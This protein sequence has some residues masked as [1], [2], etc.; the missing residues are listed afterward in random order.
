[1][2]GGFQPRPCLPGFSPGHAVA[3]PGVTAGRGDVPGLLVHQLN[4]RGA[5]KAKQE[6][7][8][9]SLSEYRADVVLLIDTHLSDKQAAQHKLDGYS[10]YHNERKGAAHGGVGIAVRSHHDITHELVW[11][12][13]HLGYEAL[14]V[15]VIVKDQ[16][17]SYTA[18][19]FPS[20]QD[21]NEESLAT[22]LP[23]GLSQGDHI[24]GGDFNSRHATWDT[25]VADR[26]EE[27]SASHMVD[28]IVG[29]GLLVTNDPAQRTRSQNMAVGKRNE[30]TIK[31]VFSSPDLTLARGVQVTAWK[32]DLTSF[33]ES[34]HGVITYRVAGETLEDNP[35]KRAFWNTQKADW[36]GFAKESDALLANLAKG[37]TP[38][39]IPAVEKALL[40]AAKKCIPKGK[41]D[42]RTPMWTPA[43]EEADALYAQAHA[44]EL[45]GPGDDPALMSHTLAAKQ[46]RDETFRSE[47]QRVFKDTLASLATHDCGR[48]WDIIR[49]TSRNSR[50]DGAVLT[51]EDG[52]KHTTRK[53]QA[54]AL[55]KQYA[56][57]A[58]RA[59]DSRAPKKVWTNGRTFNAF[60]WDE[61]KNSLEHAKSN[62]APGPDDITADFVKKVPATGQQVILKAINRTLETGDVP[63]SWRR[64]EIIP[65]LKPG[66]PA[67]KLKSY[68]P[69]TLTAHLCKLT[70]RMVLQRV[71]YSVGDKMHEAQFGFRAGRSTLDAIARLMQVVTDE[72]NTYE[73][74]RQPDGMYRI[75]LRRAASVLV[76]F[77]SAF[78]TID[79]DMAIKRLKELG[80]EAF[81]LRWIRNFLTGR[82]NWVSVDGIKSKPRQFTAG[83]PQG[84]VLGP[85]IFILAVDSLLERLSG[86]DKLHQVAYADDLT[87]TAFGRHG[88]DTRPQLQQA[89]DVISDWCKHSKMKVNIGKT[90]GIVFAKGGMDSTETYPTLTFLRPDGQREQI[91]VGKALHDEADQ[92][93]LLGI[94]LDKGLRFARHVKAA[95]TKSAEAIAQ[96]MV[97]AQAKTGLGRK[98]AINFA[99]GYATTKLSYGLEVIHQALTPHLKERLDA[100]H[101]TNVR[102]AV[103]VMDK[104]GSRGILAESG[105]MPLSHTVEQRGAIWSERTRS[106]V[107]QRTFATTIQRKLAVQR[108]SGQDMQSAHRI[109]AVTANRGLAEEALY[110]WAGVD[111]STKRVLRHVRPPLPPHA[112]VKPANLT[113]VHSLGVKKGTLTPD[114]QKGY[115]ERTLAALGTPDVQLWTDGSANFGELG[116]GPGTARS[117]AGA[118][119][120]GQHGVRLAT[121]K[122]AAGIGASS[123]TAETVAIIHGLLGFVPVPGGF[124][125]IVTD[126]QSLLAI[127]KRGPLAAT[128]ETEL[129]LWKLVRIACSLYSRVVFHHVFSH[130]GLQW[131]E[132]ADKAAAAACR[133]PQSGV[134]LEYCDARA[135]IKAHARSKWSAAQARPT[136]DRRVTLFGNDPPPKVEDT[137][138][139]ELQ[140]AATMFR[141][142][143]HPRLGSTMRLINKTMPESCRFCTPED[144]IQAPPNSDDDG[145]DDVPTAEAGVMP[146]QRKVKC[147]V[148]SQI[149]CTPAILRKHL[150]KRHPDYTAPEP[151]KDKYPCRHPDC[152]E[153][154]TSGK[155]RSAHV[156]KKHPGWKPPP[157]PVV[158]RP[159]T[160][161]AETLDHLL[162]CKSLADLR[163]EHGVPDLGHV[164]T[165][166]PDWGAATT[167]YMYEIARMLVALD[168][169][170]PLT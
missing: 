143:A 7:I 74:Y 92:G 73:R 122:A 114:E 113:V 85:M 68:R 155:G 66:K 13:S 3:V 133:L 69:V 128:T 10:M 41:R 65:L 25:D 16:A 147:P 22:I 153:R 47:R 60:T 78:D 55:A 12:S 162:S 37:K 93:K 156:S 115:C 168:S 81:E 129:R 58:T 59:P 148:C 150:K 116:T 132:E 104:A 44:N 161:P 5:S 107:S 61:W 80:V 2:H 151:P 17:T 159:S 46:Q 63:E 125:L 34:D 72:V 89:L 119:V 35:A 9:R 126:S 29:N 71:L 97:I 67:D 43:M 96:T 164:D 75:K 50:F 48:V 31:R 123:K 20:D 19:Y 38:V 87:I 158:R 140:V 95:R 112:N 1:M 170:T 49:A 131:N 77:S 144:H 86:I 139:R 142:D 15:R 52:V 146:S 64:G 108:K 102:R 24:V 106:D 118:I 124:L 70:E 157:P 30:K 94:C 57:V 54:A 84:T 4:W 167:P 117:G 152:E 138:P 28:W 8:S 26:I 90:K 6:K 88:E 11:K 145:N 99:N 103:G 32:T 82:R 121:L 23:D 130:C 111:P 39:T 91:Q 105:C 100:V 83:V 110:T 21:I 135:I 136:T 109:T 40:E 53:R 79:H 166:G 141:T 14:T 101:R 163:K 120:L 149:I 56:D 76:D 134:P 137:W 154:F 51:D 27:K 165:G 42:R 18:V 36:E 98:S 62:K 45:Y 33:P 169:K 127:L 160:G